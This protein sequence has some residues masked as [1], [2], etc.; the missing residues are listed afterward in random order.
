MFYNLVIKNCSAVLPNRI[1][2]NCNIGVDGGKIAAISSEE[3]EG[4]EIIDATGLHVFPGVVDPHTHV[5]FANMP[6]EEF[7]HES[8]NAALGGCTTMMIYMLQRGLYMQEHPENRTLGDVNCMVDYLLHYSIADQKQIEEIPQ[9]VSD[10]GVASYKYFMTCRAAESVRLKMQA[11][12]D[13]LLYNY[14]VAMRKTGAIPCVHCENMEIYFSLMPQLKAQGADDLAAWDAARP[15]W[16]EAESIFRAVFLAAKAKCPKIYIVHLSSRD[17]LEMIRMLRTMNLGVEIIV[18]TCPH[19]LILDVGSKPGILAKVNPPI[20]SRDD[21]DALWEGIV[22][23]D[24]QTIGSDHCVRTIANKGSS[25]WEGLPGF[26]GTGSL[27]QCILDYGYH[28]HG[29]PLTRIA[30]LLSENSA[31]IFGIYPQKGSV[32]VGS[33]AD[34]ALVDLEKV[35]VMTA[36][37][38]GSIGDYSVYEGM[39]MAGTPVRTILRGKTIMKDGIV[40]RIDNYSRYLPAKVST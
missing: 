20:R 9:L 13:G 23:D 25:I 40:Y 22:K 36:K 35:T 11:V 28:K 31:R 5:G 2:Y 8:Q 24:I 3:L 39:E 15:S 33:D 10:C 38:N 30:Q 14:F 16:A 7:Y 6:K 27:L 19:Y 32:T 37:D 4:S 17:G 1:M 18:E 29:I 21:V 34:F 26:I 12:D